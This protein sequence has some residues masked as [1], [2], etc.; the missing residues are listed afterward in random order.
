MSFNRKVETMPARSGSL[1]VAFSVLALTCA[2]C[3][4]A[5]TAIPTGEWA[6]TGTYVEYQAIRKGE[7]KTESQSKSATY[8]T[9]LRI[10]EGDLHGIAVIREMSC[11]HESISAVIPFPGNDQ[12]FTG[13]VFAED[14]IADTP[15][16]IFHKEKTRH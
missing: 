10:K 8:T 7:G 12:N 14:N 6:G 9:T 11:N 2:G 5:L 1:L 16:R 3:N 13:L 4:P 15:P